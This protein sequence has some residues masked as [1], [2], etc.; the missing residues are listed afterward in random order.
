MKKNEKHYLLYNSKINSNNRKNNKKTK[1]CESK[2]MP[3][4]I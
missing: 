3:Q 1:K 2:K 4:K